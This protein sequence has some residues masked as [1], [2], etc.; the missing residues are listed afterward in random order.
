MLK[1]YMVVEGVPGVLVTSPV[2]D[3][4]VGQMRKHFA[5]GEPVPASRGEH[6]TPT[7]VTL[8]QHPH[9]VKAVRTGQLKQHGQAVLA[10]NADAALAAVMKKPAAPVKG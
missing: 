8:E 3:S 6:F 5:D 7:V 9:L 1:R 4:F 2:S 10:E